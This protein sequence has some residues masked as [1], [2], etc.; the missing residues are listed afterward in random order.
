MAGSTTERATRKDAV[1]NR[2]LLVAAAVEAFRQHGLTASVNAIAEQAGV[3]IATLYR[4]FPTKDDLIEAVLDAV[5]EPL[6]AARDR[7]LAAGDAGDALATFLR[8]AFLAHSD[9]RGLANALAHHGAGSD[10]RRRLREPAI[11]IVA[12]VV[13]RAHRDGELREEL[14]EVDL[15]IALRM[16]SA[17][18]DAA[19]RGY[20]GSDRLVDAVLRGLRPDA[21]R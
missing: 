1:R 13:E 17:V 5:L 21:R 18:A 11:D 20:D 4:H 14:A 15:L 8:E 9:H 19:D 6:A 7:A 12:P 3:N 2:E 10:I 16:L